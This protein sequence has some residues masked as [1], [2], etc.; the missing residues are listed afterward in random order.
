MSREIC[1]NSLSDE[2]RETIS[3]DL[4]IKIEGSR[5]V[6]NSKP[7]YIYP[8]D[9]TDDYA[10]I[11]FAYARTCAGGPFKR[12]DRSSY[13]SKSV[14]FDGKLREE[15]NIVKKEA[16]SHLNKYGSTIISAYPGF[17]KTSGA[18]YIATKIKMKTI[19]ITHRV[20]LISQWK[21]SI[22]KF[23]PD[24]SIQVL[25]SKCS[26][27]DCDFYIMNASNVPKRP[28]DFY[29]DMGLVIV[30]ECH[31]IMAEGL[32]KCMQQLLPRYVIGLSATPYR[33]DGLDILLNLYFGDKKIHRKLYRNHD[34]YK[35]KTNFVPTVEM[36][37]NGT[38]NWGIVLD[39]QAME[40]RRNEL[41]IKIIK[42]FKD[43]VFLIMCKRVEQG[44][45]IVKRLLEESED[46]TSLL[47]KQQEF[48]QTS[49]ILVGTIGKVGVGFDHSRL[50]TLLLAGDVQ[51]YFIQILGR[52]MRTQEG[53]P[54]VI[55]IVDKNPILERHFKVRKNTYLEHGGNVR[56]FS[57]SFPEI[58]ITL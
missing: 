39:S 35:L 32:S 11:P 16:I 28:K 42:Y 25:D 46:V 26:K 5:F 40:T 21:K 36:T 33:E 47:G 43:R 54:M 53:I 22:K 20:V 23:C 45:Y 10:Y 9:V 1:I 37:K 58:E 30:D 29:R 7:T 56:E 41:I 52:V 17:G 14:K 15:Q 27:E 3:N 31:L 24:A 4:Q 48:E 57:K 51:A 13:P 8:I 6:Y 55:D 19:I 12:P 18:I 38:V 50:N 44:E 2:V 49:R 34:V